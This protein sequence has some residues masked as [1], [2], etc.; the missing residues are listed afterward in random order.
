MSLR[1][2]GT[3]GRKVEKREGAGKGETGIAR[4]QKNNTIEASMLLKTNVGKQA[5]WERS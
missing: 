1:S 2:A 3:V 5:L 4:K